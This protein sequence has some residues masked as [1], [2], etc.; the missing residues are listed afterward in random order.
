MTSIFIVHVD[1]YIGAIDSKNL[2]IKYKPQ[3]KFIEFIRELKNKFPDSKMRC[4][5]NYGIEEAVKNKI[6][7][8]ILIN[9]RLEEMRE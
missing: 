5:N 4:V 9:K 8:D 1:G 2:E 3:E 7:H 6:E